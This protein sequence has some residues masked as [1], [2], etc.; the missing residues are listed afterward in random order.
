MQLFLTAEALYF[1]PKKNAIF[2]RSISSIGVFCSAPWQACFLS[3]AF[4]YALQNS[5][6][7]INFRWSKSLLCKSHDK[8]KF[9]GLSAVR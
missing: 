5:G 4:F 9:V 1:D 7:S 6:G 3:E 2:P 8:L